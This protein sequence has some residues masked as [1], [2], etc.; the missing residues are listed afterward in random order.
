MRN[1]DG[2]QCPILWILSPKRVLSLFWILTCIRDMRSYL[3]EWS[4]LLFY[5]DWVVSILSLVL[6]IK[7]F[8]FWSTRQGGDHFPF[9]QY[10]AH[11]Q[12]LF[13]PLLLVGMVSFVLLHIVH[14]GGEHLLLVGTCSSVNTFLFHVTCPDSRFHTYNAR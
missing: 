2:S 7:Y 8:I 3:L 1:L 4:P 14:R 13:F 12:A 5:I 6:L 11:G 10:L 9:L